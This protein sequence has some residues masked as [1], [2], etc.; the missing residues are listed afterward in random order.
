MKLKL[1]EQYT[2]AELCDRTLEKIQHK[3]KPQETATFKKWF[4][5]RECVGYLFDYQLIYRCFRIWSELKN[6]LDHFIVLSGREGFGK[7]TLSFQ[8]AA[9]VNP[10]FVLG[11]VCYDASGFL[12]IL[13]ARAST[14]EATPEDFQ[15]V[16]MDEGTE[17]LSREAT[18][19][20]NRTLVKT[21]FIQRALKFLVIINIP[22]FH[23]LDSVVRHHRVRTLI[24]IL[25]RGKYKCIT[26]VG[27]KTISKE[28]LATKEVNKVHLKD[29]QFFHGY[30]SKDFPKT[31]NY[32]EYQLNKYKAIRE[33]LDRMSDDIVLRKFVHIGKIT[34]AANISNDTLIRQIKEGKLEGKQIGSKWFVTKDAYDKLLS[35]EK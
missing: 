14:C 19:I 23:M 30:F 9:W 1:E 15:S 31:I 34:K 10:N 29:G 35:I 24:E 33:T 21:F 18:N 27:I 5:Q 20:T 7:T 6:N 13:K 16:V 17:L 12:E 4:M 28:G 3:L 8:I 2:W 11:N 25:S 22:N 32:N 26:G